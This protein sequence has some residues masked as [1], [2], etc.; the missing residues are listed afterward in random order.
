M[1]P[2]DT[3]AF[4]NWFGD[5]KVVDAAGNPLVVYHGTNTDFSEFQL[6]GSSAISFSPSPKLSSEHAKWKVAEYGGTACVRP[7]YLRICNPAYMEDPS[8]IGYSPSEIADLQAKGH[9]GILS[10]DGLELIVFDPQQVASAIGSPTQTKANK[11]QGPSA[12]M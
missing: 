5:S 3:P 1:K 10:A 4:R 6:N 9:D 12:R 8:Y 11:P 2:T 7:V